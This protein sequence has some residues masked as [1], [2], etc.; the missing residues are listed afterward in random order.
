MTQRIL[1][2]LSHESAARDRPGILL[3]Q[4]FSNLNDPRN[5]K[6]HERDLVYSCRFRGSFALNEAPPLDF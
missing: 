6:Q 3:E 1:I 4:S 5:P 2:S